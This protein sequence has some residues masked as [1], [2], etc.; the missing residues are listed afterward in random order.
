MSVGVV[1]PVMG[2][3]WKIPIRVLVFSMVFA[4][5]AVAAVTEFPL[6]DVATIIMPVVVRSWDFIAPFR[7]QDLGT[8]GAVLVF[9]PSHI[10]TM[11]HLCLWRGFH[12]D[13]SG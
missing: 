9:Y 4:T 12:Q 2:L 13:V 8:E 11:L 6:R 5:A 3:I 10:G 1:A 7:Q